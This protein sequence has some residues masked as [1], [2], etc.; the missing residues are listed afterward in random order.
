MR[1]LGNEVMLYLRIWISKR[2]DE[3]CFRL[4]RVRL[5]YKK[6][7]CQLTPRKPPLNY[8][9]VSHINSQKVGFYLRSGFTC[10]VGGLHKSSSYAEHT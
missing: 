6:D 10:E 9:Y 7:K 8:P 1:Y 4:S 5:S 3:D 2:V